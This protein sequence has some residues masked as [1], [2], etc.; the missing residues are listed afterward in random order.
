M[1]CMLAT[2]SLIFVAAGQSEQLRRNKSSYILH[3]TLKIKIYKTVIYIYIKHVLYK[4][5][6]KAK[7]CLTLK[8]AADR[9]WCLA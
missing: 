1:S 8:K 5:I 9:S 3:K 2:H 7:E 4:Y 6:Y